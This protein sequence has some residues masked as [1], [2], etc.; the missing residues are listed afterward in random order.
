M[1][2]W[3]LTYARDKRKSQQ[4]KLFLWKFHFISHCMLTLTVINS[5]FLNRNCA[6]WMVYWPLTHDLHF[7]AHS[8]YVLVIW[9]LYI[10]DKIYPVFHSLTPTNVSMLQATPTTTKKRTQKQ[11]RFFRAFFLLSKWW[12]RIRAFVFDFH[13]MSSIK[14]LRSLWTCFLPFYSL[15]AEDLRCTN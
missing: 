2:L 1:I 14:M 11:Q 12:D 7:C 13:F 9:V 8:D 5:I 6:K 15:Q 3:L 4:N 10:T